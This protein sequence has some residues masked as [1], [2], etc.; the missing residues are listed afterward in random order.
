MVYAVFIYESRH[1]VWEENIAI[2]RMDHLDKNGKQKVK[3]EKIP[4][5]QHKP[6]TKLKL[7]EV[8]WTKEGRQYYNTIKDKFWE[9]KKNHVFF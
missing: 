3:R 4:T 5:Y 7:Y 2:K 9:L 8:G 6:G 1:E